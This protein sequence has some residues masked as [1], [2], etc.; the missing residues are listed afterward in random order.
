MTCS[1]PNGKSKIAQKH[2]STGKRPY[3]HTDYDPISFLCQII[4]D[5]IAMVGR[6]DNEDG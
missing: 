4:T 3:L 6:K 5:C 1:S 2:Q